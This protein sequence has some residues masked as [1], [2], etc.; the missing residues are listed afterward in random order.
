MAGVVP[1]IQTAVDPDSAAKIE[2]MLDGLSAEYRFVMPG[3]LNDVAKAT[4]T[5]IKKRVSEKITLKSGSILKAIQITRGASLKEPSRIINVTGKRPNLKF[6]GNAKQKKKGVGYRIRKDGK[7]ATIKGAFTI[8]KYGAKV[9]N[10]VS[11]K[12][13]IN[14]RV[15][16]LPIMGLHGPSVPA[17]YQ[18]DN[19]TIPHDVLTDAGQQ[20]VKRVHGRIGRITDRINKKKADSKKPVRHVATE[21]D[22]HAL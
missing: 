13:F 22:F 11:Y 19:D 4:R 12:A 2:R 1:T 9:Y 7:R 6:F 18:S 15:D 5:Q 8:A 3:A 17:I 14:K 16:R 21:A 20:L 10:R